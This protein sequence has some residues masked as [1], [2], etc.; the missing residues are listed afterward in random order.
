M[1]TLSPNKLLLKLGSQSTPSKYWRC[2]REAI[3]NNIQ[4]LNN[5]TLQILEMLSSRGV[6]LGIVTSSKKDIADVVLKACNIVH[7]FSGCIISYGSCNRRKPYGDPILL[8]LKKLNHPL[9]G[10]IYIGDAERDALASQEAGVDFGL[11]SWARLASQDDE[12]IHS[13]IELK[14]FSDLLNYT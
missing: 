3:I 2:Y 9:K 4:L 6:L 10:T 11:A 8:A 7:F 14:C 1:R 5:D 12:K 13:D